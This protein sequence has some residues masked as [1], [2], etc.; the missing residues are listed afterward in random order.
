MIRRARLERLTDQAGDRL[1]RA[2][3]RLLDAV[4][5]DRQASL[6][7]AGLVFLTVLIL[8]AKVF[9]RLISL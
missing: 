1:I 6:T 9:Y 4:G 8:T 7:V 5:S 3:D 2:I